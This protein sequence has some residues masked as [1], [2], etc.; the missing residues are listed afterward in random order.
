MHVY[1]S[2]K[3][4]RDITTFKYTDYKNIQK[5]VLTEKGGLF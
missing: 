3:M 2:E 5:A 1:I 4:L